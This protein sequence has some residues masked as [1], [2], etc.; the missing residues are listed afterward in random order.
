MWK[1]EEFIS[2]LSSCKCINNHV[3]FYQSQII[4]H[5][6]YLT[7]TVFSIFLGTVIIISSS[8]VWV[9]FLTYKIK[10]KLGSVTILK[11]KV[12]KYQSCHINV[13]SEQ[14]YQ[15]F[16]AKRSFT[17]FSSSLVK[18][19]QLKIPQVDFAHVRLNLNS[20]WDLLK[21]P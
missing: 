7:L 2:L 18:Q 6:Y 3:K 15:V 14:R 19:N 10:D 4:Q 1:Y 13:T 9:T 12:Y 8:L 17:S 21:L 11:L 5:I 16:I 20:T